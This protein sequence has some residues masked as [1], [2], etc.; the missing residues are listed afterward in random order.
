MITWAEITTEIQEDEDYRQVLVRIFRKYEGQETDERDKSNRV[1]KVTAA[2]FARHMGIPKQTFDHWL[3]PPT[4][5]EVSPNT[6]PTSPEQ[7]TE[8]SVSPK[9]QRPANVRPAP[10]PNPEPREIRTPAERKA[11]HALIEEQ[12]QPLR[13]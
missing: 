8:P 9:E 7:P 11:D 1:I 2:A 13:D 4:P 6:G 5:T 3:N 12:M 10:Q